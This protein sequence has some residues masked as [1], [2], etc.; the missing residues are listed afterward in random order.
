[1]PFAPGIP[2]EGSPRSAI[3][4]GIC[5]GRTP[6]RSSTPAT[7]I[8]PGACAAPQFEHGDRRVDGAVEVAV[9]AHDQSEAAGRRLGSRERVDHVIGLEFAAV[10]ERASR[11]RRAAPGARGELFAQLG[12]HRVAVGVVAGERG[13][14][15]RGLLRAAADRDCADRQRAGGA[16]ERQKRLDAP[17]QRAGAATLVVDAPTTAARSASGR[18][19]RADRRSAAARPRR[20][21]YRRQGTVRR[22]RAARRR[23]SGGVAL[24]AGDGERAGAVPVRKVAL[25]QELRPL[26]TAK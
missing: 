7:S 13:D 11:R 19:A 17:A 21:H 16:G 15:V 24:V 23:C 9:G 12:R 14:A 18:A 20:R 6:E 3:R 4:S 8:S 5:S 2:S 1:M 26:R 10:E 22:R 25:V